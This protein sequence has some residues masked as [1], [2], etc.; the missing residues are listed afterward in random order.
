M[1]HCT[2]L[3]TFILQSFWVQRTKAIAFNITLVTYGSPNS[4]LVF[5]LPY[6]APAYAVAVDELRKEYNY[7]IKHVSIQTAK[8]KTC[9]DLADYSFLVSQFYYKS[10]DRESLFVLTL[11]GK[12]I[13][14]LLKL[15]SFVF[16]TGQS[17]QVI[18]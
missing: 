18:G 9:E 12:L 4:R 2:I 5:G 8:I 3:V 13:G 1:L 17:P 10:W 15:C 11:P 14:I 7:N 6:S 16:S